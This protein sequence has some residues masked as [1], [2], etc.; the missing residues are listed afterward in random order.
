MMQTL[1]VRWALVDQCS[2]EDFDFRVIR[3]PRD[4]SMVGATIS[5]DQD[6]ARLPQMTTLIMDFAGPDVP[7]KEIPAPLSDVVP[8][9]TAPRGQRKQ[10]APAR[11]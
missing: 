6:L 3:C 9:A 4:R 2:H 11:A 7:A 10:G 1:L 8:V 5:D